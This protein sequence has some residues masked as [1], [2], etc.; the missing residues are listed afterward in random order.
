MTTTCSSQSQE[1]TS[2]IREAISASR[3]GESK[4]ANTYFRRV[5]EIDPTNEAAWL[6][7]A[8]TAE[9]PADAVDGLRAALRLNPS[10]KPAATALPISLLRAGIAAAKANDRVSALAYLADATELDPSNETAWLWRAGVTEDPETALEHLRTVLNLNPGSAHAKS[11]VAKLMAKLKARWE[12]PIC[13]HQPSAEDTIADVCRH[14]GG[15]VSLSQPEMFDHSASLVDRA[16]VQAAVKRLQAAWKSA[17]KPETAYALGL[18]YLNLGYHD[19]AVQ[20]LQIAIRG[21]SPNPIWK[22]EVARLVKHRQ[23]RTNRAAARPSEP[24]RPAIR[25]RVMVVDDSATVRKMVVG[26]LA[27]AGYAVTEAADADQAATLVRELG[28]PRLF[29]LDVNMPGTD[30][31]GLCKHLRADAETARVPVVFLTGKT[32]LLNKIHGKW[33]GAAEYLTKP[34]EP[35]K[36]AATVAR[37]VPLPTAS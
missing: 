11:G 29:L 2:L 25:P 10:N 4:R 36:L 18:A 34:F 3:A 7:L 30:G 14:C 5:T 16:A 20:A 24:A 17:T 35:D 21:R 33:V 26:I 37:L 6:W 22:D 15:V 9:N 28:A 19:E 27:K 1:V 13:Q 23:A 12:C 32:G 31:F 8:N